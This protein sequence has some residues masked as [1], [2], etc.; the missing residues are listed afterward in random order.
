MHPKVAPSR[1][2]RPQA[3]KLSGYRGLAYSEVSLPPITDTLGKELRNRPPTQDVARNGSALMV[4]R[5]DSI[6][7]LR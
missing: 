1:F 4:L 3:R 5:T 6:V 2:G 7:S